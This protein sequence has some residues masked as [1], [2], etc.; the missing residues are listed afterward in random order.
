MQ[1]I[2]HL[3][4]NIFILLSYKPCIY[5]LGGVEFGDPEVMCSS[6]N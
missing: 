5:F 1:I 6:S 3:R 2:N 4:D